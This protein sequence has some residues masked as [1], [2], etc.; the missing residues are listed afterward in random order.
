[1]SVALDRRAA[2]FSSSRWGSPATPSWRPV[3]EHGTQ[4]D[5]A[6]THDFAPDP[7]LP[8]WGADSP[9]SRID[10]GPRSPRPT[11]RGP[12]PRPPGLR[13][14]ARLHPV[15]E[16]RGPGAG[17]G[18]LSRPPAHRRRV[19]VAAGAGAAHRR[20]ARPTG[21]PPGS[22]RPGPG[23]VAADEP[24]GGDLLGGHPQEVPRCIGGV[25]PG[26]D[27]SRLLARVALR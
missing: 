22:D 12:Q 24:L 5:M 23:G 15:R 13:L 27:P 25:P 18:A 21:G 9:P 1:E 10:G 19:V 7:R 3:Y 14:P 16:G 26:P 4:C 20:A 8:A 17:G 11:R 6:G 2:S